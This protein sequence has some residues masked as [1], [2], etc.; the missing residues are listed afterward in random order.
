MKKII[1]LAAIAAS[2][3]SCEKDKIDPVPNTTKVSL[4][5]TITRATETNFEDGDVI[6]LYIYQGVAATLYAENKQMTYNNGVFS[7]DLKWHTTTE[8]KARLVAYYPYAT[9][10]LPTTFTVAADQSGD[11]YENSDILLAIAD[12]VT[13]SETS[14]ATTFKHKLTKL[15]IEVTNNSANTVTEIKVKNAIASANYNEVSTNYEVNTSGATAEIVTN[16]V[17]ETT[18]RA[19][20][21]PQT[22][23]LIVDVVDSEGNTT[24]TE[25]VS[26]D[27]GIG[28]VHTIKVEI[29][30]EAEVSVTLSTDIE[31]W[32]NGG[33]IT[34]PSGSDAVA[35]TVTANNS[36]AGLEFTAASQIKAN[37]T[38]A[39]ET[40]L[41]S[42]TFKAHGAGDAEAAILENNVI[43]LT[44][45]SATQDFIV[46]FVDAAPNGDYKIVA[47]VADAAG[48]ITTVELGSISVIASYLPN[49]NFESWGENTLYYYNNTGGGY[50]SNGDGTGYIKDPEWTYI[51]N[52]TGAN[53]PKGFTTSDD[54]SMNGIPTLTETLYYANKSSDCVEGSS[55]ILLKTASGFGDG[56]GLPG[57]VGFFGLEAMQQMMVPVPYSGGIPASIDGYFKSNV[58]NGGA[59]YPDYNTGF[60]VYAQ[61]Y[62]CDKSQTELLLPEDFELIATADFYSETAV[63]EYTKFSVPVVYE[64]G[65]E[66]VEP[67]YI[68]FALSNNPNFHAPNSVV[69]GGAESYVDNV[70]FVYPYG[71]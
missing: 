25:L 31:D 9:N 1:L 50:T 13:P 44:G 21:V 66:N 32:T 10:G 47:D 69:I 60:T 7:S 22:V 48:N 43:D 62:K 34:P 54:V 33:E 5:P 56:A 11:A 53:R 8:D 27:L 55:A 17:N 30:E 52:A 65:K 46:D 51:G 24:S 45:T 40:E 3:I 36:L 57:I 58:V 63:T 61:F 4:L 38:V 39:D 68:I 35:P 70:E 41:K 29:N 23:A 19:I 16:K 59:Y 71:R 26:A 49:G 37:L 20:V 18:Y 67:N 2:V 12:D 64:E 42:V 14:V 6:G 28:K 15:N